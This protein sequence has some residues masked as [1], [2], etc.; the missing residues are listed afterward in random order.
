MNAKKD[1]PLIFILLGA[2]GSG[3]GTQAKLLSQEYHIPQV[4]TGDL[5]RE[6]IATETPLGVQVKQFIQAGQLVPDTI[7][8]DMVFARL[9]KTDCKKGYLLDGV[10]RTVFQ[11]EEMVKKFDPESC[12]LALNL[13]VADEVIIQRAKERLVCRECGAIYSGAISRPKKENVCDKCGGEVYRRADDKEEVVMNRLK[14]YH[15]QTSPLIAH[16]T[17]LGLLESFDGNQLPHALFEELKK[18]INH[19]IRKL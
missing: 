11:A 12:I 14:I 17:H 5:F 2:P 1:L 13:E 18:Y 9:K 19:Q 6:N 10:P 16:F 7:V 8:L 15:A 4:S 3:K